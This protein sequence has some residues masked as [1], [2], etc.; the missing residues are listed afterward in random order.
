MKRTAAANALTGVLVDIDPYYVRYDENRG[1]VP[2]DR[3]DAQAIAKDNT[4][5]SLDPENPVPL[6]P[7]YN[8]AG[9][10]LEDGRTAP[11]AVLYEIDDGNQTVDLVHRSD[12]HTEQL[13]DLETAACE[14]ADMID[15]SASES[16]FA[17]MDLGDMME[18]VMERLAAVEAAM[19]ER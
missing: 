3:Q 12:D 15:D 17:M 7:L 18:Q 2:C 8:E 4:H 6:P 9:E 5:Y 16:A 11:L 13:T 10:I 1:W 19:E 14:I